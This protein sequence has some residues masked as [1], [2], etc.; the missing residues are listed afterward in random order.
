MPELN[1]WRLE[2]FFQR[3]DFF[4]V[5]LL[6]AGL[7]EEIKTNRTRRTTSSVCEIGNI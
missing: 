6:G 7:K 5:F 4:L 3:K 1:E 2:A